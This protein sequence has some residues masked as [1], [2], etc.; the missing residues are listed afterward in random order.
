MGYTLEV[1]ALSLDSLLAE[2]RAPSIDPTDLRLD[3]LDPVMA[4]VHERWTL[5]SRTVADAMAGGG[6]TVT[7]DLAGYVV[8]VVRHLGHH[9]TSLSHT[10]S[11]GEEFRDDLLGRQAAPLLGR[12][13]LAGLLSRELAGLVVL[14]V[15]MLGWADA[16]EVQQ[17]AATA[18]DAQGGNGLPEEVDDDVWRLVDAVD[19]AARRGHDLVGLYL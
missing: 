2:L 17:A 10:S 16:T 3:D 7:D 4:D 18:A 6:G 8:A 9:A 11:G 1:W 19:L 14:D 13:F 15:P 12:A 5:L